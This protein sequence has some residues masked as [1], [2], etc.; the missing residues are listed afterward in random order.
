MTVRRVILVVEDDAAVRDVTVQLLNAEPDLTAVGAENGLD[1]LGILQGVRVHAVLTDLEMPRMDGV[2]LIK[3]LRGD[4]ATR[5]L[6]VVVFSAGRHEREDAVLASGVP[7]IR[8]PY[9]ADELVAVLRAC[10]P[11]P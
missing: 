10:F 11:G 6:P 5:D 2:E 4:R 3:R 9:D 7:V 8:K 1:A